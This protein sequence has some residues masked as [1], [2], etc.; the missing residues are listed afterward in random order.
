[1]TASDL[2]GSKLMKKDGDWAVNT[3]IDGAMKVNKMVSND[4]EYL[5]S[6]S[7]KL[8]VSFRLIRT[9]DLNELQRLI[10]RYGI[11]PE[12]VAFKEEIEISAIEDMCEELEHK[13]NMIKSMRETIN[14]ISI[15]LDKEIERARSTAV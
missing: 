10:D 4:K 12:L 3:F 11:A 1:M 8:S 5:S 13:D 6:P 7:N 15:E 2:E 9:G 14:T